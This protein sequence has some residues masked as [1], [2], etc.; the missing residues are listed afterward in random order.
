M[1][2][3]RNGKRSA[4]WIYEDA[5]RRDWNL[6]GKAALR[7]CVVCVAAHTQ[8]GSWPALMAISV[9]AT[10]LPY[11]DGCLPTIETTWKASYFQV[12]LH[13]VKEKEIHYTSETG[14]QQ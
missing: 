2:W 9:L 5:L 13:Y 3:G 4:R 7:S 14:K 12:T 6:N 11:L 10:A 1:Y 8:S